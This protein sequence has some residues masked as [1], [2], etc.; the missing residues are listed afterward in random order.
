MKRF[1]YIV[2][3]LLLNTSS[4]KAQTIEKDFW[5]TFGQNY[6]FSYTQVDLQIRIVSG[7]NPTTG[8]IYFTNLGTS[9]PFSM[10]A[11]E[12]YTHSL[13]PD[14]KEAV[15]NTTTGKSNKTV[16]INSKEPI[17]VYALN[18]RNAAAD[19]TNIFPVEVL[20]NNYYQMSYQPSAS[21]FA[22]AYATI[23]I[24]NNTEI[25]HNGDFAI[26]LDAGE[27]YYRTSTTDMTGTHI[28]A[29]NP[30]AFFVLHKS[31]QIPLNYSAADPL[32]QQLAPVNTWGWNFF[33]P[34][35]HLAKDR[36]RIVAAYNDTKIT[37]IGGTFIY[38]SS[39]SDIINVGQYIELEVSLN[40]NG[41]HI[42]ANKPVGV[43]T[44]LT[45]YGYNGLIPFESDPAQAWLPAIE[46]MGKSALIA[47]FIP[48][49]TSALNAHYAIITT[50]F[51][52]KENTKVSIGGGVPEPLS[53]GSWYNN[54]P[55]GMSF[56]HIPLTNETA[57]YH[58]TNNAGL[59]VMGYG[60]GPAESY[61]YLAG[62]AMRELDAAFYADDVH[63]Q[64]LAENPFCAG[65]V[66]FR[67]EIEGD[68]HPEP[69]HLK[70]YINDPE[71]QFPLYIDQLEW[72]KTFA[73]GEYE[74]EMWV[75]YENGD[76]ISKTGILKIES[77]GEDPA[78]YAN[79][80]HHDDLPNTT[81]CDKKVNFRAEIDE[82][83]LHPD[84]GHL[85]W[86]IDDPE[87]LSPLYIDQLEWSKDFEDGTY[88]IEMEVRFAN[89]E[90]TTISSTMKVKIFWMKIRNVRY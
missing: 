88:L 75:R 24:E 25:Y 21:S 43:C 62:S 22:D 28:T 73:I 8:T 36:V 14:Q 76:P 30:I 48:T 67:A 83:N 33:V 20:S 18:Q 6:N 70:W 40:D 32:M 44:Y 31:T 47:P 64:D 45:G 82:E 34:V 11:Y 56:Y 85:K 80:I 78:F 63:F 72:N 7:N 29:N 69:E 26:A 4:T 81:F 59:M 38:S 19:A 71:R 57:S 84:A 68:L 66:E 61:Y 46:Q 5:L 37:P 27:V 39:G 74:I 79:D 23:A 2:I 52:T 9:V 54:E 89:G 12:V 15:Y 13:L 60:T 87:R 55:V 58:F 50:P 77:C 16:H 49:G 17:K 42:Q 1:F 41:C 10:G 3:A 90:T 86:Y 65:L 51:A 35:S 53:G